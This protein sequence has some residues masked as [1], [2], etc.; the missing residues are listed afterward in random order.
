MKCVLHHFDEAGKQLA[1]SLSIRVLAFQTLLQGISHG[2][3]NILRE[4]TVVVEENP[5]VVRN[6]SERAKNI[7]IHLD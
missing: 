7:Q 3:D 6:T 5:V 4:V 1:G 2:V